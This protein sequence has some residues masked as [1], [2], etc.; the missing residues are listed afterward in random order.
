MELSLRNTSRAMPSAT[1]KNLPPDGAGIA[2]P[3]LTLQIT[4]R[5]PLLFTFTCEQ[6]ETTFRSTRLEKQTGTFDPSGTFPITARTSCLSPSRVLQTPSD[7]V[8]NQ[9]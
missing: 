7:S 4:Y 8:L 6:H 5:L 9:I 1:L 3:L 2:L